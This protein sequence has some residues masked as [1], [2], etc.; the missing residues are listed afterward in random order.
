MV[1]L[2][3]YLKIKKLTD[4]IGRFLYEITLISLEPKNVFNVMPQ[5]TSSMKLPGNACMKE[6]LK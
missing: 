2:S 4:I 5:I 3:L 1:F 6:R